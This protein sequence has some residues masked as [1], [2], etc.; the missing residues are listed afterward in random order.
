MCAQYYGSTRFSV[1]SPGDLS[2]RISKDSAAAYAPKL[3]SAERMRLRSDVFLNLAL[4][5]YATWAERFEYRHIVHFSSDLPR[6]WRAGLE[7]AA[8]QFPFLLLDEVEGACDPREMIRGDMIRAG[9]SDGPV[10]WFRVDDDD[11]LAADYLESLD[12][13]ASAD[14][15]GYAVSF[16]LGIAAVYEQG[17]HRDFRFMRQLLPSAGQAYIGE[18]NA[19]SGALS[20]LEAGPHDKVDALRPVILD[21]REPMYLQ[22]HHRHQDKAF[23]KDEDHLVRHNRHQDSV[24]CGTLVKKFPTIARSDP[25]DRPTSS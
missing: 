2:W 22:T 23:G 16:G 7:T 6:Q 1:H 18:F 24:D 21:S 25:A 5:V 11:V 3:F 15:M 10:V 9:R 13:F 4:P 19:E 17:R 12:S 20:G 8:E 14:H